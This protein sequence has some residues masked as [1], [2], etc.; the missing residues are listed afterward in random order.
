MSTVNLVKSVQSGDIKAEKTLFELLAP[1]LFTICRRYAHD[2]SQAKDLLQECFIKIYAKIKTFDTNKSGSFE[3]WAHQVSV[4]TIRT[5]I[6]EKKRMIKL[7]YCD[8]LPDFSI[9][10][11]DVDL[12]FIDS[13]LLL[14]AIQNLPEQYRYVINCRIF[15]ECSH[16]EIAEELDIP[17]STSRSYYN[18]AKKLLKKE[19]SQT[20]FKTQN[21]G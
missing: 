6:K 12:D 20:I 2:D 3:G 18:R 1:N 5:A 8:S 13:K 11:E 4:N 17:V 9:E 15:E 16:S 14:K 19:L 21:Y 7:D 10:E